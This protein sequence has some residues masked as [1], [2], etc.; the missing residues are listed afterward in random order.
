VDLSKDIQSRAKSSGVSQSVSQSVS[1]YYDMIVIIIMAG[2]AA[3][4]VG[5]CYR[6][7]Q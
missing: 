2:I 6:L 7:Y 5:H 3:M 4:H 1:R